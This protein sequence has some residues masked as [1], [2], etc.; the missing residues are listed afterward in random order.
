MREAELYLKRRLL[1]LEG[2]AVA[3]LHG[4]YRALYRAL[5]EAAR[6]LAAGFGIRA[7]KPDAA[8]NGWRRAFL[9]QA[10]RLIRAR[11]DPI[12]ADALRSAATAYYAGYWGRVWLL[13]MATRADHPIAIVPPPADAL[14]RQVL[15]PLVREDVY[16]DLIRSLLGREW[17]QQFSTELDQLILD[18]RRAIGTGLLDG[19]GIDDIMRRVRDAMGITTDRRLGPLN[20]ARRAGYRANFNRVQAIVRTTV[21]RVSNDGAI[22]AYRAHP[23]VLSG[24]EWLT[25]R[26]ER[27]CPQCAGLNGKVYKLADR[28]RPPAHINCRCTII[29]VVRQALL[30]PNFDAPPREPLPGW[31]RRHGMEAVLAD[32]LTGTGRAA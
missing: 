5:N 28:T 25:A 14:A 3:R 4:H 22:S 17:R 27:V 12:A 8:G 21:N 23:D 32:F 24:Y 30:D 15:Q 6:D 7:V 11:V 29:P 19:E 31:A 1:Y 13:D 2:A 18:I 9:E 10:E 16:D 20:S 26:D